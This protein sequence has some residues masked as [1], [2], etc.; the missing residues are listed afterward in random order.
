MRGVRV[1]HVSDLAARTHPR[2]SPPRTTVEDT[3]LDLVEQSCDDREAVGW[4]TS[5]M[6]ARKTT[7]RRLL[8]VSLR[9]PRLGRRALVEMTCGHFREGATSP[10]EI[11]WLSKVER[12]HHLPRPD[13]QAAGR[14][15]GKRVLRDLAYRR[16]GV[17]VELDG[18]LGHEGAE[19]AFR[20]MDRDNEAVVGGAV[21]LRFG[22][23]AVVARS[24]DCAAQVGRVLA[25]RGWSGELAS[26]GPA[27]TALR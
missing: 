18:R 27:C 26:C 14:V 23:M 19:A 20:D 7:P 13:R 10:L 1:H 8:A 22:W 9:R 6:Q 5:A 2:F 15:R 11:G 25:A 16:Y 4:I 3:A 21:T 12:P 24:C 17:I